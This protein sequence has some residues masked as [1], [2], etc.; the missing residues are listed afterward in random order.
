MK[1]V[2]EVKKRKKAKLLGVPPIY[3][4]K[5]SELKK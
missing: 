5:R 1:M 2:V 3:Q 4:E